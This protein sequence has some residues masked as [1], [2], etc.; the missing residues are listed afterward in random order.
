ME[1]LKSIFDISSSIC[2]KLIERDGLFSADIFIYW[3]EIVGGYASSCK[4]LKITTVNG[5]NHLFISGNNCSILEL[6]YSSEIIRSKINT[7]F[8]K[9]VIHSIKMCQEF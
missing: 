3:N 8:G 7:F 4:P 6:Q 9:E 2:S 1:E 5:S